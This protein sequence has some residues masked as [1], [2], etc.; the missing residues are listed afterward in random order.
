[1]GKEIL[2]SLYVVSMY[3]MSGSR[4]LRDCIAGSSLHEGRERERERE[5]RERERGERRGERER[6]ERERREREREERT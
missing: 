2:G 1:M 4:L 3:S 5:R 6:R